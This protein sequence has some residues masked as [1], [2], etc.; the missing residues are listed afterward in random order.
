MWIILNRTEYETIVEIARRPYQ[1]TRNGS[2][3]EAIKN[4]RESLL[5]FKFIEIADK[6]G[7]KIT[8]L[9]IKVLSVLQGSK[10]EF[11]ETGLRTAR[12][13]R[14]QIWKEYQAEISEQSTTISHDFGTESAGPGP[15]DIPRS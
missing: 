8:D 12:Q 4:A 6:G 3:I 14:E 11:Y 9:G 15:Y 2:K 7:L 10:K 1:L 13:A 5:A